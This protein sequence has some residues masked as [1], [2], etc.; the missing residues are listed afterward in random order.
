MAYNARLPSKFLM[1]AFV[2]VF[3]RKPPSKICPLQPFFM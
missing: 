1:A 2:R 3:A